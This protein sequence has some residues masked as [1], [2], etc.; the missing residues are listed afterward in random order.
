MVEEFSSLMKTYRCSKVFGDRHA[1]EW[2]REQ[3]Q[4]RGI[5]YEPAEKSKSESLMPVPNSAICDFL[6]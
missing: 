1:G 3:F 2:P 4:K 5:F 6:R